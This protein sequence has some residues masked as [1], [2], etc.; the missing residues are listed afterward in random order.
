MN[1]NQKIM[2]ILLRKAESQKLANFYHIK[3]SDNQDSENFTL[4]WLSPFLSKLLG[5]ENEAT[6]ERLLNHPDLIILGLKSQDSAY[7]LDDIK[8]LTQFTS[9]KPWQAQHRISVIFDAHRINHIVANKLLKTLEEPAPQNTILLINTQNTQLLPTIS[10]RAITIRLSSFALLNEE[11]KIL[12]PEGLSELA[13]MN[14][15]DKVAELYLKNLLDTVSKSGNYGQAHRLLELT[16]WFIKSK[17]FR[18]S[19]NERL[20]R[21]YLFDKSR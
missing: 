18:N 19:A 21:L 16:R 3:L 2:D 13:N 14:D 10:S 11:E 7:T 6:M 20:S 8:P 17:V 12:L 4:K 5:Y 1:Y 9:S 15:S